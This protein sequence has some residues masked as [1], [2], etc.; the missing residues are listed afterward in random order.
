MIPAFFR[1]VSMIPP[2]DHSQATSQYVAS[3]RG[4]GAG[5]T[6]EPKTFEVELHGIAHLLLPFFPRFPGR[7]TTR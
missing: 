5:F 6:F 1:F 4:A 2:T 3:D 7:Y